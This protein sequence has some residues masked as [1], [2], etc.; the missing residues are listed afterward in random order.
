MVISQHRYRERLGW[1]R[2]L[3]LLRDTD[4]KGRY[5]FCTRTLPGGSRSMAVTRATGAWPGDTRP[6]HGAQTCS[7]IQGVD[8]VRVVIGGSFQSNEHEQ[9]CPAQRFFQLMTWYGQWHIEHST[10]SCIGYPRHSQ[11]RSFCPLS[12]QQSWGEQSRA[13]IGSI[14]PTG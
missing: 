7:S 3:Q 14:G 12:M 5:A 13:R 4:D 6:G 8:A 1:T 9:T 10:S 2:C 11:V